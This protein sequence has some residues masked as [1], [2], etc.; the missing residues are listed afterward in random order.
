MLNSPFGEETVSTFSFYSHLPE[1]SATL[2]VEDKG[3]IE[4]Q[5]VENSF[6]F[7]NYPPSVAVKKADVRIE[8][9]SRKGVRIL[10]ADNSGIQLRFPKVKQGSKMTLFYG[11]QK[12]PTLQKVVYFYLQLYIGKKL[13]RRIRA[14]SEEGWR[15]EEFDL[16]VLSFLNHEVTMTF[17]ATSDHPR[18]SSI[19]IVPE[20][21]P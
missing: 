1:A 12:K 11:V 3:R 17:F 5:W 20:I 6:Q 18:N 10:V 13:I 16:G 8:G 21:E 2:I 19:V 14:S 9:S 7:A 15:R 4:G